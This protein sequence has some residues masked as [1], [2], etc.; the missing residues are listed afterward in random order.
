MKKL[1][2]VASVILAC[3]VNADTL[4]WNGGNSGTWDTTTE[5]WKTSGGDAT[6]GIG[7]TAYASL[8][9]FQI[10]GILQG[11][12]LDAKIATRAARNLTEIHEVGA[13]QT[14]EGHHDF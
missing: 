2:V 4:T 10:A 5:N 11:G 8:A 3:T 6:G 12:N 13:L 1:V 7:K 9:D 14:V